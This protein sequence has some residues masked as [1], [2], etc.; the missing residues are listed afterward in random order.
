MRKLLM[1]CATTAGLACGGFATTAGAAVLSGPEGLRTAV[2]ANAGAEKVHCRPGWW[3]HGFRPHDG[4]FRG[5]YYRPYGF[6]RGPRFHHRHYG[7][8]RRYWRGHRHWR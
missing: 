1:I 8:P 2:D 4:C 6:Y 5:G 7:P 3:H